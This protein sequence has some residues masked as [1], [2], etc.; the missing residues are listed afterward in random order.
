MTHKERERLTG[1]NKSTVADNVA[2]LEDAG[3]VEVTSRRR[4]KP[5]RGGRRWVRVVELAK[6]LRRAKNP[7]D[8]CSTAM[9]ICLSE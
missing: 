9:S 5:F 2:T 4:P 3:L 7:E 6:D 8:F 1:K